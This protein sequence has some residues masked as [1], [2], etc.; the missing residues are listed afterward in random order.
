MIKFQYKMNT[1]YRRLIMFDLSKFKNS[2]IQ[3]SVRFPEDIY[4]EFK[5]LA[6]E[7]GMSFNNVVISCIKYALD[8]E[9]K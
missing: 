3:T 4:N 7:N 8:D 9:K 2:N 6:K 5:K 1:I